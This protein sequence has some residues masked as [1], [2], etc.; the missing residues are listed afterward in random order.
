MSSE[1]DEGMSSQSMLHQCLGKVKG[2][3]GQEIATE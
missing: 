1:K 2:V 3:Q